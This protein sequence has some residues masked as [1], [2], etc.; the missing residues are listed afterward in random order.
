MLRE[1]IEGLGYTYIDVAS[2][3]KIIKLFQEN[4]KYEP[5]L[6]IEFLYLGIY[7]EVKKES[8]FA[9][10]Y[11]RQAG[12][13]FCVE[14]FYNLGN[15]YQNSFDS[16]KSQKYYKKASDLGHS[17]AAFTLAE[18]YQNA[19]NTELA[20]IYYLR[21][22]DLGYSRA[23]IDLGD[24]YLYKHN[25]YPGA[26]EYYKKAL[27]MGNYN[28]FYKLGQLYCHMKKSA[29]AEEYYKLGCKNGDYESIRV[30]I[31]F[32]KETPEK[33]FLHTF[34]YQSILGE[35]ILMES[36]SKLK[37]PISDEYK[38]EI[39]AVLETMN[40]SRDYKISMDV[41]Y[42]MQDVVGRKI[43]V[44]EEIANKYKSFKP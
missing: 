38:N 36:L 17:K 7:Y 24:V 23:F 5:T 1:I 32:Y 6:G 10:H 37:Y 22:G 28:A 35:S 42:I 8:A 2:E 15:L 31:D 4:I 29:Q 13:K 9:V 26:E 39:Y 19:D 27:N 16:K 20:E 33:S 44:L 12:Q 11:Y 25:N 34:K 14:A 43:K 3:E 40:T 21:A 18:N 41:F 30:L